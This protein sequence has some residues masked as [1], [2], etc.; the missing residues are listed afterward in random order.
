M[1]FVSFSSH[2]LTRAHSSR[3]YLNNIQSN[4]RNHFIIRRKLLDYDYDT[5]SELN[6]EN[7]SSEESQFN[8]EEDRKTS[9]SASTS[10]PVNSCLQI[11]KKSCSSFCE[12]RGKSYSKRSSSPDDDL[13]QTPFNLKGSKTEQRGGEY[14]LSQGKRKTTQGTIKSTLEGVFELN[15]STTSR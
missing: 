1:K 9:S 2:F 14:K 4:N 10:H 8:L 7:D 13:R 5:D 11:S 6:F 3:C 12:K 15:K